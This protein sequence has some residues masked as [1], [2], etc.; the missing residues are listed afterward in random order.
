[1]EANRCQSLPF[2]IRYLH[3]P[4][5][6]L[7]AWDVL[8]CVGRVERDAVSRA[9]LFLQVDAFHRKICAINCRQNDW[10]YLN[11]YLNAARYQKT[12]AKPLSCYSAKAGNHRVIAS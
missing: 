2:C 4:R 7:V 6:E 8:R 10:C 12:H 9:E 5:G 3:C 1:L 11:C